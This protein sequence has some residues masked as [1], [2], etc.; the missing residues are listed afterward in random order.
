MVEPP[1]ATPQKSPQG[2]FH[3]NDFQ[4]A[5]RV[6]GKISRLRATEA[7]SGNGAGTSVTWTL[8]ELGVATGSVGGF[9]CGGKAVFFG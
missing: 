8:R 1:I 4:A 7:D 2:H 3:P 9:L 5:P 6:D